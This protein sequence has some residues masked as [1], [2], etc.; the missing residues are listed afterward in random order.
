MA[1]VSACPS[2]YALQYLLSF[3][4]VQGQG[5]CAHLSLASFVSVMLSSKG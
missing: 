2:Q 1:G 5:G 4:A 3:A